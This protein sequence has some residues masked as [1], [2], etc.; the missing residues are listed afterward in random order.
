[1]GRRQNKDRRISNCITAIA[2]ILGVSVMV[3]VSGTQ[4]QAQPQSSSQMGV[5]PYDLHYIDMMVMHHRQGSAM[6]R[7]AERKGS[8]AALKAFAKK[9]ADAQE[10]ELLELKKHRDHWYAGA[11]EMDHSQM[12]AQMSGMSGHG[13]MKMDMQGDMA[14]LQAATGKQFDRL[15][16]D[17]MVPHHQMAIDMSKEA[18]TKAEHAEIKE[19]ARL[20]VVKQQGEI[21]EMNRLKGGGMGKTSK[22]KAKAKSKPKPKPKMDHTMH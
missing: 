16:L 9:T 19:M 18:V 12:M 14:R 21:A 10:K 2:L 3:A 6:A 4:T 11:T 5:M 8:T 17:M 13:N 7:L 15:F 1:M 20:I 22:A